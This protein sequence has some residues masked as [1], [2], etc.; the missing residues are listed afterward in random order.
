MLYP[1]KVNSQ[2]SSSER[3]RNALRFMGVAKSQIVCPRC[4]SANLGRSHRV[5]AFERVISKVRILP[6]RCKDCHLRFW[7]FGSRAWARRAAL[8]DTGGN[9]EG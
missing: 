4:L 1:N 9:P 8:K 3:L 2:I 6:H 5:N 7:I